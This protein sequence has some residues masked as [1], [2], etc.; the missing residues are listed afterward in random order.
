MRQVAVSI[1][2]EPH[3][4]RPGGAN[5]VFRYPAVDLGKVTHSL[6]QRTNKIVREPPDSGSLLLEIPKTRDERSIELVP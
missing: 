5:L 4:T 3:E 1:N 2:L 6:E